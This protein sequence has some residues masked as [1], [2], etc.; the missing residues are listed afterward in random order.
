MRD[1]GSLLSIWTILNL[2][3]FLLSILTF[4]A[5]YFV[6]NGAYRPKNWALRSIAIPSLLL[7]SLE[8]KTQTQ[9]GNTTLL[10]G[11]NP[12]IYRQPPSHEVDLAWD[13]IGDLRLI[14]LTA[15]EVI[16]IGQDP[17]SAVK[18]PPN[19][20]LGPDTYAGRLDVFHQI[21][22]LD[23]LRREAYFDH[24]YSGVFPGGPKTVSKMHSLHL[25]HCLEYLLQRIVCQASTDVY[26]HMWTDGVEHPF[27]DFSVD[28]T[29]KDFE[30]IKKWHEENAVDVDRFVA[31]KA[32]GDAKVHRMTKE[33][34]EL[35]GWFETHGDDGVYGDEIA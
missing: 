17:S 31:L 8:I 12:S 18:F 10:L 3:L 22:C 33:F 9:R 7:D 16:A 2:L 1:H 30:G 35:H 28:H 23:A 24:Y 14:P 29:C 26:T 4:A 15:E 20:G 5:A 27:P 34:K 6:H 19:F 11:P 25:S 13:R 21:H 32:P